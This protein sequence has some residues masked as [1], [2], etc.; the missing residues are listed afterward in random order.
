MELSDRQSE[1]DD[2]GIQV[3]VMTYESSE[4]HLK[5]SDRY[6]LEYPL[7]TDQDNRHVR[8]FGILNDSYQ[9]DNR[10]YGIPYP[11]IFLV[12]KDGVVRGKFSEEGYRKRPALDL[13]LKAAQE[14]INRNETTP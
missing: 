1:F 9:P 7:L 8:T 2:L 5:F 3:A 10:Y 13:I 6:E 12:D 4:I 11:G 14:M